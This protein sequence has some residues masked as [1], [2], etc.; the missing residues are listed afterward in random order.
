MKAEL[1]LLLIGLVVTSLCIPSSVLAH[2]G[3]E[4]S[5]SRFRDYIAVNG[6][7]DVSF[8]LMSSE[9]I[10][11]V[12]FSY[13]DRR[14]K[15]SS[16]SMELAE[17]DEHDGWWRATIEPDVLVGVVNGTR[18][19]SINEDDMKLHV[20]HPDSVVEIRVDRLAMKWTWT[21]HRTFLPVGQWSVLILGALVA[22]TVI[23]ISF[24][25][26]RRRRGQETA[27]SR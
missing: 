24:L 10:S 5:G 12:V 26:K 15:P 19:R 7:A 23:A 17:G 4:V 22:G 1:V 16:A 9:P 21:T 2:G 18:V 25:R 13:I 11:D 3:V 20:S 6:T 14:G 27:E 8:W